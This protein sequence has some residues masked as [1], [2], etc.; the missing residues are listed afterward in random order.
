MFRDAALKRR[1]APKGRFSISSRRSHKATSMNFA[2]ASNRWP[3]LDASA[4]CWRSS[5]QASRIRRRPRLPRPAAAG[6]QRLPRCRRT[7]PQKL[8]RRHRRHPLDAQCLRSGMGADR[9]T[10]VPLIRQNY[11]PNVSSFYYMR[12]HGRNAAA[13]WRHEKSEDRYN[14][15]TRR[16]TERILRDRHCGERALEKSCCI[17]TTT[18][19]RSRS[20]TPSCSRRRWSADRGRVS[21]GAGRALSR[22]RRAGGHFAALHARSF[23]DV[24]FSQ[25]LDDVH[26]GNDLTDTA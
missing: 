26:T 3:R 7:T 12:L 11:L 2:P 13:W 16:R 22:A 1:P 5:R 23:N 19:R 15:F 17:R 21:A 14:Y 4:H 18:S 9:R 10:E 24:E 20:S 25:L 8:E 6:I